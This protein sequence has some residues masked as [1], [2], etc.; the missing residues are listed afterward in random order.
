M[1]IAITGVAMITP[2]GD[3]ADAVLD[4]MIAGRVGVGRF[5]NL[6]PTPHGAAVG[7]DLSAYDVPG[8]VAAL[9]ASLPRD[10]GER[11]SRL[12]RR[13]PWS[14]GLTLL[15]TADAALRAGLFERRV[16]PEDLA[17][18]GAGNNLGA[19]YGEE[20]NARFTKEP[21]YIDALQAVHM[22]DSNH[23][24]SASELLGSKGAL[25]TVGAAC[26]SGN[27]GLRAAVDELHDGA[28]AA[29]VVAPVYDYAATS[30][31]A[32]GAMGAT[33]ESRDAAAASRPFDEA[34]DG[35]VPSHG[36]AAVVLEPLDAALAR[37]ARPQ[38]ELRAVE[39][40]S[41]ACHRPP[42]PD[43][44]EQARLFL[45]ALARGGHGVEELDLVSAHAAST[46]AGD[47][48]EGQALARA[49][50]DA[51]GRALVN[52][53]KGALGHTGS[54][55]SLIQL[56]LIVAQLRR[57]LTHGTRNLQAPDPRIP[58]RFADAGPQT[59]TLAL[60]NAFGLAG[61]NCVSVVRRWDPEDQSSG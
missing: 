59:L 46:P 8:R 7:G 1:R 52:A 56:G 34:R 38:A 26:A 39:A 16:A 42:K 43:P 41:D 37:G 30:L 50:G 9:R 6:S 27:L 55:A 12:V 4:E 35:F 28:A 11:L 29:V 61:L 49:L 51:A 24:A 54:A 58:L 25:L 44:E 48:A 15:V 5:A 57:G 19:R 33:T 47:L 21:D 31:E 23:A 17:V 2:L 36:A 18:I 22:L 45:R 53:P 13:S 20:G 14:V 3:D 10:V 40:S 32:L 60:N